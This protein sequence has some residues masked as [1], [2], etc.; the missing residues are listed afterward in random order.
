MI[1]INAAR[2]IL[3]HGD[4]FDSPEGIGAFK[5]FRHAV[6]TTDKLL[7]QPEPEVE[8]SVQVPL[9]SVYIKYDSHTNMY[10][11]V[12]KIIEYSPI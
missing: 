4:N 7:I 8:Y 11:I 6:R 1:Q 12:Y 5:E 9:S 3:A 10:S 2:R